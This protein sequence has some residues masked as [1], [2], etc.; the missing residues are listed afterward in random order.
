MGERDEDQDRVAEPARAAVHR[1]P[2]PGDHVGAARGDGRRPALRAGTLR[3]GPRRAR[4]SPCPAPPR[5][6]LLDVARALT[7]IHGAVTAGTKTSR[8]RDNDPAATAALDHGLSWRALIAV[9]SRSSDVAELIRADSPRSPTAA[10]VPR[11]RRRDA[12]GW[13][14]A[15]PSRVRH[16]AITAAP[17]RAGA[18][19]RTPIDVPHRTPLCQT[20]GWCIRYRSR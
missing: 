15:A 4:R 9:S 16:R 20:K 3:P 11:N 8:T 1:S 6:Q 12:A 7:A 19:C 10:W 2:R 18:S 5:A 13:R 17:P 14:R